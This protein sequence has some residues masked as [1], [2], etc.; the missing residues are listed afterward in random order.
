M[1]Q[2]KNIQK[3]LESLQ[4]QVDYLR[5]QI[6]SLRT[7]IIDINARISMELKTTRATFRD[8]DTLMQA[9][10]PDAEHFRHAHSGG[11]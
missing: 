1:D 7:S 3:Q 9:H 8:I 6:N 11:D 10:Q 5:N 4:E 2:E